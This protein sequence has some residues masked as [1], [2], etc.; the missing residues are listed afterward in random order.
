MIIQIIKRQEKDECFD[1]HPSLNFSLLY[2]YYIIKSQ[3]A[4]ENATGSSIDIP[5]ISNA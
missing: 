2:D 1:K 4:I 3:I 5:S